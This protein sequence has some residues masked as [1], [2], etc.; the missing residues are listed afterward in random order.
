MSATLVREKCPHC[1]HENVAF[2]LVGGQRIAPHS[3]VWNT[4][5]QCN[6]CSFPIAV[7][8]TIANKKTPDDLLCDLAKNDAVTDLSSYPQPAPASIPE[9]VPASIA[10]AFMQAERACLQKDMQHAAVA[11]DRRTLELVTKEQAPEKANATLYARI[12]HLADTGKLTPALKDWA[13][14]LRIVGNEALHEIEDITKEEVRQTHELTRFTLIYL[15]T[16][17]TQVALSRE[18]RQ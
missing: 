8:M 10:Q 1:H 15:Y 14:A 5:F 16:L 18:D 4:V 2:T 9:H 17:P 3:A 6:A 13:H 11:M 12:E 7:R